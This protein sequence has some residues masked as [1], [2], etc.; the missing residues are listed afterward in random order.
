MTMHLKSILIAVLPLASEASPTI[1]GDEAKSLAVN[2]SSGIF[3]PYFDKLQPNVASFLDIPYAETP[4]GNLRFAPPVAK[5]HNEHDIVHATKLPTGCIQ[6]VPLLLRGTISDGPVTAG[7]FQRGD[8]ANTTEDCLKLSL[9]A[10]EKSIRIKEGERS[11]ALPVVV[12]IH[13]GGYSVGGTNVPYQLAQNWV[14]RT[15][16]HIVVQVQYRLNLLGFPNA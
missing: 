2:T 16:K 8:Y 3:A 5:K 14:Q 13:G 9:F 11:Q 4:V 1:K 6:Y 15:R 7:T 12:W 10:P